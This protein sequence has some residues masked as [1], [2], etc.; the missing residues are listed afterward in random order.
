M[1]NIFAISVTFWLGDTHGGFQFYGYL[2]IVEGGYLVGS[3]PL[4]TTLPRNFLPGVKFLAPRPI[5]SFRFDLY[6]LWHRTLVISRHEFDCLFARS[7]SKVVYLDLASWYGLPSQ[8]GLDKVLGYER[9]SIDEISSFLSSFGRILIEKTI[10]PLGAD[11]KSSSYSWER[12]KNLKKG[13][14]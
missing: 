14:G 5:D 7:F 11:G 4:P 6:I 12:I 1:G 2:I 9:Y 3:F 10:S 13:D 8:R